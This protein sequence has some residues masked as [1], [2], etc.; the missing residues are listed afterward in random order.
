MGGGLRE[1][2]VL[3]TEG[4]CLGFFQVENYG[5]TVIYLMEIVMQWKLENK[6]AK[7]FTD[8][9]EGNWGRIYSIL[10]LVFALFLRGPRPFFFGSVFRKGSSL[11]NLVFGTRLKQEVIKCALFKEENSAVV[12]SGFC[13]LSSVNA[14]GS[15]RIALVLCLFLLLSS[16]CGPINTVI[17]KAREAVAALYW[18]LKDGGGAMF[19]ARLPPVAG[20]ARSCLCV[21]LGACALALQLPPCDTQCVNSRCLA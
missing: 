14:L 2:A 4:C 9:Q 11:K 19:P 13:F 21:R 20:L 1:S 16:A 15:Q 5:D 6:L 18:C 3:G 10:L 17:Q 12:T 7:L 8:L